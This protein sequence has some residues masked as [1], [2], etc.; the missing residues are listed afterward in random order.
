[1][2]TPAGEAAHKYTSAPQNKGR[3]HH[4]SCIKTPSLYFNGVKETIKIC[5][6]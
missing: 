4:F 2:A 6:K 1:M 5:I 3:Y